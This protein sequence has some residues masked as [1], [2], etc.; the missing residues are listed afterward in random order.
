MESNLHTMRWLM[1]VPL[2]VVLVGCANPTTARRAVVP[3][4]CLLTRS[5]IDAP[6]DLTVGV[7]HSIDV[8]GL[9]A[10]ER[11]TDRVILRQISDPLIAIDCA[12]GNCGG[13]VNDCDVN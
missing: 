12:G 8:D 2:S 4:A 5:A 7:A 13:C 1:L 9:R 10:S 6:R 3:A 11:F